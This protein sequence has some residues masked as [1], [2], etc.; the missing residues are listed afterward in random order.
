MLVSEY[1]IRK[2]ETLRLKRHLRKF[3][4]NCRKYDITELIDPAENLIDEIEKQ[5]VILPE[6]LS[7]QYN[8]LVRLKT[9]F[10][11][12]ILRNEYK[13]RGEYESANKMQER[14]EAWSKDDSKE[15]HL[16][17][18]VKKWNTGWLY[19]LKMIFLIVVLP[20]SLHVSRIFLN[21]YF[22]YSWN[23]CIFR[24]CLEKRWKSLIFGIMAIL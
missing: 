23:N 19:V 5:D 22:Y 24:K 1:E 14:V 7:R 4:S 15:S 6:E 20:M 9:A 16:E 13:N 12:A 8:K 18:K 11:L 21:L 3:V 10:K 2:E 17:R